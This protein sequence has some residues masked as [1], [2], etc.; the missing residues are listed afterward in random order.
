MASKLFLFALGLISLFCAVA[1]HGWWSAPFV[2]TGFVAAFLI[3]N[4]VRQGRFDDWKTYLGV[5]VVCFAILAI[6]VPSMFK[7]DNE[8]DAHITAF[9]KLKVSEGILKKGTA[10]DLTLIRDHQSSL[11]LLCA[12][13]AGKGSYQ[14]CIRDGLQQAFG[15]RVTVYHEPEF[16]RVVRRAKIYEVRYEGRKLIRYDKMAENIIYRRDRNAKSDHDFMIM[17]F[18][19]LICSLIYVALRRTLQLAT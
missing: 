3:E 13:N 2:A 16:Q 7:S 15:K 9:D 8:H 10:G 5:P 18:L 17:I 11:S 14:T 6:G 1:A 12:D 19:S 4:S